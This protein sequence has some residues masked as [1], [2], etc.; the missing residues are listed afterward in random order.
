MAKIRDIRKRKQK[1]GGVNPNLKTE[2]PAIRPQGQGVS[3]CGC[4][5]NSDLAAVLEHMPRIPKKKFIAEYAKLYLMILGA[6]VFVGPD[7]L[8]DFVELPKDTKQGTPQRTCRWSS[9]PPLDC[10]QN[11][12]SCNVCLDTVNASDVR[13]IYSLM[14]AVDEPRGIKKVLGEG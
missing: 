11:N 10:M 13:K 7:A 12:T 4:N 14:P 1:R 3:S 2:R 6:D 5:N 8:S 9:D